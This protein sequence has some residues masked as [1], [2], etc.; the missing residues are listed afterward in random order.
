MRILGI[1]PGLGGA[2]ALI[3]GDDEFGLDTLVILDMPLLPAGSARRRPKKAD[4]QILSE[5][6]CAQIVQ[7]LKPDIAIIERVGAMPGQGIASA[8]NFG[9]SFGIL[10]GVLASNAVPY[11][12]VTP[13]EWKKYF[14]LRTDKGAARTIASRLYPSYA[15]LFVRAKDHGR[16]EAALIAHYA[17]SCF[18][19]VTEPTKPPKLI[20]ATLTRQVVGPNTPLAV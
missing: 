9:V 8:F 18:F 2:F 15:N 14:R 5:A 13:R 16:A 20:T 7:L 12:L 6:S 3:D 11:R 17:K 19:A 4:K 10:R 1:D